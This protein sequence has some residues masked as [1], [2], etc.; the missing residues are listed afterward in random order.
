VKGSGE[1]RQWSR[2]VVHMTTAGGITLGFR[3]F[4]F[5]DMLKVGWYTAPPW[6]KDATEAL[7]LKNQVLNWTQL[8]QEIK[9]VVA[10][11]EEKCIIP[12]AGCTCRGC[13]LRYT[14]TKPFWDA[15]KEENKR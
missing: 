2:L 4:E 8:L 15:L 10:S 3:G 1:D 5:A 6:L 14:R 7:G 13:E 9:K 11:N 12:H